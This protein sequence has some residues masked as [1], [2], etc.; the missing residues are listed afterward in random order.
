MQTTEEAFSNIK[1]NHYVVLRHFT[2]L[3][4]LEK[5]NLKNITQPLYPLVSVIMTR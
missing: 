5:K 2:R 3:H 1:L 4:K